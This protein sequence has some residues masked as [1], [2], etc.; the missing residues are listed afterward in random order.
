MRLPVLTVRRIMGSMIDTEDR[1]V[2][3]QGTALL[4]SVALTVIIMA[5][6]FGLAWNVFDF[7]RGF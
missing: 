2:L 4:V 7:M 6:V 1:R 5:A 3:A